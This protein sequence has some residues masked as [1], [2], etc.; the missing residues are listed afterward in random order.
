M[1]ELAERQ[2]EWQSR[3]QNSIAEKVICHECDRDEGYEIFWGAGPHEI[4]SKCRH[5]GHLDLQGY[6]D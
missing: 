5:C 2:I 3:L 6:A 1:T 4:I